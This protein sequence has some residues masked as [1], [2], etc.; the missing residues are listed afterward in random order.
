MRGVPGP[1]GGLAVGFSSAARD[2]LPLR[3]RGSAT[4]TVSR[5]V[6]EYSSLHSGAMSYL[7]LARK[8]R[9]RTFEEVCG[10]EVPTRVL[11]GAIR[12][13]R[14][15]HAYMF[16]GPRGTGKTTSARIFAKALNCERGPTPTPCGECERCLASDAGNEADIIEI[17][18]AS[19]RRI[20]EIRML[21]DEVGYAP[22]RARFKVYIIDEVHMLT[23]EA[24][25]ALLKTLEEPPPH[26]KFLF[27]TTEPHKV[28]E[29]IRSRCQMIT[30][31]LIDEA[32]I[33]ARL[34]EILTLEQVTPEQGVVEELARL[35]RGSM[36][37]ALSVTDQLLALVGTAPTLDDMRH[38]SGQGGA[39]QV[40]RLLGLIEAGDRAGVLAALPEVESAESELVGGLMAG[41][42]AALIASLTPRPEVAD[43]RA[44]HAT[45]AQRAQR[46][47]TERLQ[48]WLEELLHAR[49]RMA[50][51]PE[52]ARVA[53]EVTLLDLCREETALPL[54]MIANRL[55]ALEE[56]LGVSPP[57]PVPS[58]AAAPSPAPPPAAEA[59][60]VERAEPPKPAPQEAPAS[61]APKLVSEPARSP[62]PPVAREPEPTYEVAPPKPA[63]AKAPAP[64]P[65]R[66][67]EPPPVAEVTP[68]PKAAPPQRAVESKAPPPA[69]AG[70]GESP[71]AE[72]D[73]AFTQN[74]LELFD[75]QIEDIP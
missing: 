13:E 70:P 72:D 59:P 50:Q 62:E 3:A 57:T 61:R 64:E 32:T 55:G 12:E 53:L 25:N 67:A 24:F 65:V 11:Q 75:G 27:A 9:P 44:A 16:S 54:A 41:V 18:A 30:L 28:I 26:A 5:G 68:A 58:A 19:N 46:V 43:D 47:G 73:E 66:E 22:M 49:E 36:R 34:A 21:R 14:I 52:H 10:Q 38:V 20:E 8:Y 42:R 2:G 63:R 23:K 7:V 74:V 69:A 33:A 1:N 17:D 60:P 51:L 48:I 6:P 40:E 29:T 4:E 37:D 35:A 45:A 31:N 15:G 56:R 39:E 71:G